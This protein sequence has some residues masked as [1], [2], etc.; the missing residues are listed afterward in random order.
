MISTLFQIIRGR[1]KWR[2]NDLRNF[3]S[4]PQTVFTVLALMSVLI[5]SLSSEIWDPILM[6]QHIL[7]S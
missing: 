6:I 5:K 1:L 7:K 4:F 3:L 2:A